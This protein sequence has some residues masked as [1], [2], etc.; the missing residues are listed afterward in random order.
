MMVPSAAVTSVV[1][2]GG[3]GLC[4]ELTAS[5]GAGGEADFVDLDGGTF[6]DAGLGEEEAEEEAFK[7][8]LEEGG[9]GPEEEEDFGDED[10]DDAPPGEVM[11]RDR[12]DGEHEDE[13]C[14]EA[15]S[16]HFEAPGLR[17]KRGGAIIQHEASFKQRA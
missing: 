4:A 2:V 14:G 17:G 11:G 8:V 12:G 15:E 7:A 1:L 16:E 13:N 5:D 10:D 6:E 9:T 3:V